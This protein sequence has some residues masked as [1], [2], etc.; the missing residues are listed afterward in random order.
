MISKTVQVGEYIPD[1]IAFDHVVI[2][3][4]AI[5]APG[6][7]ERAQLLKSLKITGMRVGLLLNVTHSKLEW[8]RIILSPCS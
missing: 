3:A 8:K 2:D 1:L 5:E 6:N 4:K 7:N